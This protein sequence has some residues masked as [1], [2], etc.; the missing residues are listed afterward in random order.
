MTCKRDSAEV[1]DRVDVKL[2]VAVPFA[3][4]LLLT[5]SL[6]FSIWSRVDV[7][8]RVGGCVV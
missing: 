6:V 2:D 3:F 1:D 8:V 7:V 4:F 5:S